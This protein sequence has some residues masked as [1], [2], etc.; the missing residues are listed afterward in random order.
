MNLKYMRHIILAAA[1]AAF[2]AVSTY[3]QTLPYQNKNLSAEERADD[4]LSRMTIEE[5]VAQMQHIHAK[6]YDDDG[7]AD[8]QKLAKS[9]EGL[10]RGCMEAFPY[11]KQQYVNAVYDIQKYLTEET[12]LGIPALTVLE[13]LHGVVQDGC[14][15]YPQAIAQ[16]ATFKP[17][18]IE[19]MAYQIALEARS[20]GAWQVFAPCLD[21]AR[22]LRWGRVEETF[23]EDPYMVAVNGTAYV[24]GAQR[25]GLITTPKHFVA[26]GSP[27]GGIN[28]ATVAG[29]K[30]DLYN[31]YLP[32]FK[33]IIDECAPLSIMN[34]YSTY[35][36][37]AI[38]ASRFML[39][40]LLRGTLG[41]KG[42]VYSDWGSI[43]MLRYFHKM[44][45]DASQ[46]AKMAIEAGLDM[47][48]SSNEYA[49]VLDMVKNGKLDEK[50]IDRAV[51]NILYTKF[52]SGAFDNPLPYKEAWKSA[53]HTPESVVLTK[54]MAVES[55]VLL[56]N[57]NGILP[58]DINS[59]KSIA[60]IGPNAGK[61]QFGDYCWCGEIGYGTDPLEG[62]TAYT[63]GKVKI[64]YAEGCDPWSQNREGFKD[65]VKAAKKSDIALV[66]VGSQSSVFARKTE[67]PTAGEGYDLH[68]L[69]LPGVQ[70]ELVDAICA[71]GTPVVVVL[72]T[73][74]PFEMTRIREKAEA[75]V[76]Q[77]YAGEEQGN[78]IAELLFGKENFSGR[79]PVSFPK[80]TGTL[81]C[82]YNHFPSDKGYYNRKG[83]LDKPGRDY[84]F[85]DPYALYTFGYG[86]SYSTFEY[87]DMSV[88]TEDGNDAAG[89]GKV[90]EDDMIIVEVKVRN[91]SGRDGQE[92]VQIYSNDVASS[93][94]TPVKKLIAFRKVEI[95]AGETETVS[96]EIPMSRLGF[97]DHE[98]NLVVEPGE[99]KIMAC[100]AA[101]K[102]HFTSTV[103]VAGEGDTVES[104]TSEMAAPTVK[105]EVLYV[106]F[107][108]RDIQAT[109][110]EGVEV[111][112]DGKTIAKTNLDGRC[113]AHIAHGSEVKLVKNGYETI[114]M[115]LDCEGRQDLTMVPAF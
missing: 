94:I 36:G 91:T 42:F 79:L 74:K 83:S 78:A 58:L 5:K 82:F 88:R 70:E 111:V 65:A 47:E 7:K 50:Y 9:T 97:Y 44:A 92:T 93:M 45:A 51:W 20:I 108:M 27:Q 56:E 68:C 84:V 11:S 13:G 24:R 3:G 107:R 35:D 39:T 14:T 15:I 1:I 46:A 113:D 115:I 63:D 38:T 98:M 62:I 89:A 19:E 53:I 64:N 114:R 29:G 90:S 32:A 105:G 106:E 43:G 57:R 10:S 61:V 87:M 66:F 41:F 76:V 99:F 31:L 100:S 71:T 112:V 86:L 77:W 40:D 75:L 16:A 102:T 109:V 21:L 80:S 110:L 33:M 55:A 59:Y 37:E 96:F 104:A 81:P 30:Y 85:T 25:G 12:R 26:H 67:P 72:V 23:G 69:K 17:E 2:A 49:T 73:G 18:L 6:H 22:E 101:D 28:L 54:K 4:L 34:C 52:K 60:V 95:K 48:A 8:L 103:R